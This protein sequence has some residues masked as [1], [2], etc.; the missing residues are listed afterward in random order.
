[1]TQNKTNRWLILIMGMMILLFLGLIYAWSIFRAPLSGFFPEWNTSQ[2]SM[3]F[4]ISMIFFCLGGFFSGQMLK[5]V[6][7]KVMLAVAAAILFIGFFGV[8]MLD[9][10]DPDKSLVMLYLM[11][12]V[13]G[14]GGVGIGYNCVISTVNKWFPDKPGL[15]SGVMLLGFGLG[16]IVLGGIVNVLIGS[17]GLFNTFKVLAVSITLV[18]LAGV[19][20]LKAPHAKVQTAAVQGFIEEENLS[21]SQMLRKASFWLFFVWCIL[22]NSAGLMIINNAAL[23]AAAFGAPAV[24][25]LVVS[26]FNGL[27]RVITG[28]IFD[29]YG[30][31]ITMLVNVGFTFTAGVLLILG[32]FSGATVVIIVGLLF[33]G[34]GYGATPAAGAAFVNREYGAKYFPV[35]FSI[36]NF[37]L[38]P[39]SI[40][41]PIISSWLIDRSGGAYTGTFVMM[42][43]LAIL[44]AGL[45]V[46]LNKFTADKK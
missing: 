22:L 17:I 10:T 43:I 29:K 9:A 7:H 25:G 3:A 8:S 27:S 1:M 23:I 44:A 31:K 5:K 21:P 42:I 33:T 20:L 35:N 40:V 16:G 6:N 37:C 39:A 4:T 34:L 32:D 18:L 45:W 2:M 11:Y 14:G 36:A 46:L 26:V 30:R 19:L 41:G 13:L 15:A 12:G 38:I 24:L 28:S